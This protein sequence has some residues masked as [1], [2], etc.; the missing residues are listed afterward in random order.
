MNLE[1]NEKL[2]ELLTKMKMLDDI[3][4]KNKLKD[5]GSDSDG[6]PIMEIREE[7]DD[8]DGVLRS[9]VKQAELNNDELK[10][11]VEKIVE[12]EDK[13][14]ASAQ[15]EEI[16]EQAKDSDT[17]EE[18]ET[19]VIHDRTVLIKNT[20]KKV[21]SPPSS[22]PDDVELVQ[23][24]L[25]EMYVDKPWDQHSTTGNDHAAAGLKPILKQASQSSRFK[26]KK[27]DKQS[28][29]S[30]SV[31]FTHSEVREFDTTESVMNAS[32][33]VNSALA[34]GPDELLSLEV[35]AAEMESE[36]FDGDGDSSLPFEDEF[37]YDFEDEDDDDNEGDVSWIPDS[38]SANGMLWS[39]IQKLRQEKERPKESAVV[40]DLV[41]SIPIPE[42][43]NSSPDQ[44]VSEVVLERNITE[45]PSP[46]EIVDEVNLGFNKNNSND[47]EHLKTNPKTAKV[48]RFK[49]SLSIKSDNV[50]EN[51]T[52][53][54]TILPVSIE[55]SDKIEEIIDSRPATEP[56]EVEP[57]NDISIVKPTL[58][59]PSLND[60]IDSM[61]KAYVLG[62]YDD[63]IQTEGEVVNELKD[64]EKINAIVE[65]REKK[66]NSK[67]EQEEEE[68]F[69]EDKSILTDVME[70]ETDDDDEE[71]FEID[72]HAPIMSVEDTD[73]DI[74]LSTDQLDQQI[75]LEY[76]TLRQKMVHLYNGG[77][78][79]SEKEQEIEPI[80]ENGNPIKISRF[81]AARLNMNA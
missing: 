73:L 3:D 31:A 30:K 21:E 67:Q 48:S 69:Q 75:N 14:A 28:K 68:E 36:G 15:I 37:D 26:Q 40:A 62:L 44:P 65:A 1:Q 7:L 24:L 59:Y 27:K 70:H 41:E 50:M 80:D 20:E 22:N 32:S 10:T 33:K 49:K 58:D 39:Q 60:D 74:Q 16:T 56:I 42:A 8:N 13:D 19:R 76:H 57:S 46:M 61:A 63:D 23:D 34:I 51:Y 78:K 72:E 77:F 5:E 17:E 64:F 54:P 29:E 43:L 53:K 2:T 66:E 81:R 9:T 11:L 18:I 4:A 38:N 52:V 71:E 79:K 47:Q 12:L 35:I 6:L 45:A 55:E 25:E